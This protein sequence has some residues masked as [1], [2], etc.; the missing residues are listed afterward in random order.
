MIVN[1]NKHNFK[2]NK[3]DFNKALN[4]VNQKVFNVL[5]TKFSNKK[6]VALGGG[7]C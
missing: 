6:E 4:S 2:I 7:K 1:K 5:L 3:K